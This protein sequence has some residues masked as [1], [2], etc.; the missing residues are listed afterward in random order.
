M[1]IVDQFVVNL[2]AQ[3]ALKNNHVICEIKQAEGA[4]FHDE[5]FTFTLKALYQLFLTKNGFDSGVSG[6]KDFRKKIYSG[7]INAQLKEKCMTIVIHESLKPSIEQTRY[8]LVV[9]VNQY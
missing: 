7:S 5:C 8:K 9:D 1:L 2:M 6:Y 3:V 4:S